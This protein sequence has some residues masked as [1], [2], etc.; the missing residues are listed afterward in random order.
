[1]VYL[2]YYKEYPIYEPAEGGY[3]YSGNEVITYERLSKR[4]ARKNMDKLWKEIEESL[5]D[6]PQE[7]KERW[8]YS[9]TCYGVRIRYVSKYVGE[10]ESYV[11]ERCLGSET[12]GYKPYC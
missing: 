6:C 11:I 2:T 9:K 8:Y 5:K 4:Q 10:G 3:Y 12:R 1:M 7:E